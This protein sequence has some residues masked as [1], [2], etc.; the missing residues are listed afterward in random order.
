MQV[1]EEVQPI[2]A[3]VLPQELGVWEEE[4]LAAEWAAARQAQLILAEGEAEAHAIL[5]VAQAALASS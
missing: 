5:Q 3:M 1:G 2:P 4:V